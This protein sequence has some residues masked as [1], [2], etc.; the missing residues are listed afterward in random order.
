MGSKDFK[1]ARV[2]LANMLDNKFQVDK[3]KPK[4]S[5]KIE[6]QRLNRISRIR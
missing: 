4:K 6:I 2:S 5:P 3:A 1:T